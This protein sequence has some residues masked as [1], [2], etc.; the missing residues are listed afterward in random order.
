MAAAVRQGTPILFA[1]FDHM[2]PSN[3]S[4]E[5]E[6]LLDLLLFLNWLRLFRF[7]RSSAVPVPVIHSG[8]SCL[9]LLIL[10]LPGVQ[11]ILGKKTEL[12]CNVNSLSAVQNF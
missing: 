10:H 1:T 6:K 9:H 5:E 3:L 11:Q 12:K 4:T 2:S 7:S 8:E